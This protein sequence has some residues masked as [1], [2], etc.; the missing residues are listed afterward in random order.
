[1]KRRLASD[2]VLLDRLIEQIRE[3]SA[4]IMN[5][6]KDPT[7]ANRLNMKVR[8]IEAVVQALKLRE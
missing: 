5:S 3:L 7:L 6:V 1:M 8:L 2:E 4:D